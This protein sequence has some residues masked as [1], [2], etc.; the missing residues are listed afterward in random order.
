MREQGPESL[1]RRT[2]AGG[3]SKFRSLCPGAAGAVELDG[4]S[5]R[6]GC[7]CPG[8]QE[9]GLRGEAWTPRPWEEVAVGGAAGG[10]GRL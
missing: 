8:A 3:P 5:G 1:S 6:G 9:G 7:V 10:L 2:Q 4:H